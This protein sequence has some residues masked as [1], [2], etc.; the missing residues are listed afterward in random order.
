MARQIGAEIPTTD[1][2]HPACPP[3]I[4]MVIAIIGDIERA[5]AMLDMVHGRDDIT[6]KVRAELYQACSHA[7]GAIALLD[8]KLGGLVRAQRATAARR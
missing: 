5:V 1:L 8:K 2:R 7:E 6:H 3:T 4:D